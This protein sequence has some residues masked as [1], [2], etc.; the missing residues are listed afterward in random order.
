MVE[1]I[2]DTATALSQGRRDRQEDAVVADFQTGTGQGF[3][4]LSDGMGGHAGGDV[5]SKI[6]VTEVFA[7]LKLRSGDTQALETGMTPILVEA[8]KGANACLAQYAEGDP[9]RK[10]MGATLL[11]PVILGRKLYWVSV[12]DSPLFLLREGRL[13]RL[14]ADHSMAAHLD[15]LVAAGKINSETAR[16]HPDRACVTSVLAGRAIAEIDCPAQPLTLRPRDIV[17]A[18]SDGLMS[19]EIK[20]LERCLCTHADSP[21]A[22]IA[23][24][25]LAEVAALGQAEQDNLAFCV[26]RVLP[27]LVPVAME[28]PENLQM[29]HAPRKSFRRRK[30]TMVAAAQHQNGQ[31][32]FHSLSKR[33][34]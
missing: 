26:I 3:A 33:S 4:V 14:N 16:R 23:Q 17:V 21:A 12:G 8:A 13:R 34:L 28:P 27:P 15:Q 7:E 11:A 2:Y 30:T 25:L 10:G 24:H 31:L 5:A 22:Q 32:H 20:A 6:V 1:L 29:Q 19:M 9:T 18:A